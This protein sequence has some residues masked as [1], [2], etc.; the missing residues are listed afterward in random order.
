MER[1]IILDF[2]TNGLKPPI[3]AVEVAWIE[4]DHNFNILSKFDSLINPEAEIAPDASAVHNIRAEQVENE[5]TIE[6]IE[7]PKGEICVLA[8]NAKFDIDIA[9][10]Y[11][12]ITSQCDSLVLARRLLKESPNHQLSTLREYCELPEALAHRAAGDV[13]TLLE[14][15][16]YLAEGTGW[17]LQHLIDYSNKP[18]KLT[19]VN[20]GKHKNKLFTELPKGYRRWMLEQ[21]P[22][23]WDIDV[24]F[25]LEGLR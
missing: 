22:E 6:E 18:M 10:P 11:M 7:F 1:L 4:I 12:N 17:A 19:H 21:R 8:H 2:E 13:S 14:L 23:D 16:K 25:T 5:P 9:E 24:R 3:K 20:F 15:L